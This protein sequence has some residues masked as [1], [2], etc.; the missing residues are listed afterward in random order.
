MNNNLFK[1]LLIE[2]EDRKISNIINLLTDEQISS[3]NNITIVKS[4][5]S[6]LKEIINNN[7][8]LLILDMSLPMFDEDGYSSNLFEKFAGKKILSEMKVRKKL[9]PTILFTM[10]DHFGDQNKVIS[11]NQIN[12][13]LNKY[14]S[15]FYLG[16]VY[17]SSQNSN[18]Q[19]EI[20]ELIR[21]CF[22]C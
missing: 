15:D 7:F 20:K 12:V 22:K 18:W 6:G 21:K 14:F 19:S 10:F 13:E 17:F 2:D 8:N 1:V 3:Q 11:L 5:K 4:Y 9:I 16:A